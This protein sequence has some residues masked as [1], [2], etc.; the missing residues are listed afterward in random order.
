MS[1]IKSC[2]NPSSSERP[3]ELG[4]DV[5]IPSQRAAMLGVRKRVDHKR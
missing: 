1:A 2:V 4:T 3:I 5:T